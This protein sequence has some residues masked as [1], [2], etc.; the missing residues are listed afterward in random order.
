MFEVNTMNGFWVTAKIAGMESTAKIRSVVS[1]IN[2]TSMRGV[3]ARRPSS[4][5]K[6]RWPWKSFDTGNTLR[7]NRR[8]MFFSGCTPSSEANNI[9]T[10]V[11][12]R[13]APKI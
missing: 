3:S 9:F 5:V 11:M 4:R 7:A 6:N 1:T 12:R 10:P 8:R 2:R 13:N